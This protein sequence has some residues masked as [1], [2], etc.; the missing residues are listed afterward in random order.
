[1][2]YDRFTIYRFCLPHALR[3]ALSALRQGAVQSRVLWVRILYFLL[4]GPLA[5]TNLL[6][7]TIGNLKL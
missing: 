7:I 5:E 6:Q 4:A 1:M 3:S 2:A